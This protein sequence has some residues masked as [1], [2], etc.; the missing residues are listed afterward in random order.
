MDIAMH[1]QHILHFSQAASMPFT[2]KPLVNL[3][4]KFADT[5]FGREFR[6]GYANIDEL[7]N[8]KVTKEYLKELVRKPTDSPVMETTITAKDI[9]RNY[10]N[11]KEQTSTSPKGQHLDL[12][13][14][15]LSVPEESNINY[16]GIKTT[17]FLTTIQHLL[18][19]FRRHATPLVRW[20]N[21]HNLYILKKPNI[22]KIHWLR[23]IQKVDSVVNMMQREL[24][25]RGPMKNAKNTST[26]MMH[27]TGVEEGDPL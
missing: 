24:I 14:T 21:V 5:P 9:Q 16:K 3:F 25:A 26:S 22:F 17:D 27:N 11:W 1:K 23:T 6:A 19:V 13:K 7:Q 18:T 15:W 12:Y 4:D 20:L 10:K 8:D 2:T